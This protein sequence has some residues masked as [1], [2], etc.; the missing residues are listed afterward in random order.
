MRIK[1]R[2]F[3]PQP[4]PTL[5]AAILFALLMSLGFWQLDRAA[6]KAAL[7]ALFL[8]RGSAPPILL[9]DTAPDPETVI[10]RRVR[11]KGHYDAA[12]IYLLD[13]QVHAGQAGYF[14][15]SPFLTAGGRRVL[16][17]RGWIPAGPDRTRAPSVPTPAG[18]LE[19]EGL[20]KP[21]PRTPVLSDTP[22]ESL[23]AGTWRVQQ[24]EPAAI[25][26]RH[27][28]QLPDYEVRLDAPEG[29]FVRDWPAAGSGRERHLGYA[30]QWFA[31]AAV[32]FA[33]WLV[34][35]FRRRAPAA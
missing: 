6:E 7:H 31:L 27:H 9:D 17:S 34:V 23:A 32:L 10:W 11:L 21:P 24:V 33:I 20:A 29:G 12:V 22:P 19:L 3:R 1:N 30:F 8:A 5:I 26:A 13:N 14:V 16:V 2:E 18:E 15:Y 25:G 4:V 28:W 35:N